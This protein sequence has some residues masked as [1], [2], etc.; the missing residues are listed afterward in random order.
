MREQSSDVENRRNMISGL[1][2][3]LALGIVFWSALDGLVPFPFDLIIGMATG[4][5]VGYQLGKH[6]HGV[7][8]YPSFITRRLLFSG[9][10][11]ILGI[12]AFN[13]AGNLELSSNQYVLAS[14]LA[15]IP[16]AG[17]IIAI[18]TAIGQLDEM[19]RRIQ[20]EAIAIAFA[21]TAIGISAFIFLEM[22]GIPN[23]DY[24]WLLVVIVFMWL[25]GKLWTMWR[26]R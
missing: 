26:Y 21:G 9:I 3:G 5:I 10:G 13:Y 24:L 1:G 15:I 20:T 8:R 4:L 16:A 7:M 25:I 22:A 17:F 18:S 23:P 2:I 11:L 6:T 12:A 14:L 19:Q